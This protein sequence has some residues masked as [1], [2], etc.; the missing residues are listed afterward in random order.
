[1]SSTITYNNITKLNITIILIL[2]Y[3]ILKLKFYIYIPYIV[4]ILL[5]YNSYT[6]IKLNF[7]IN[8]QI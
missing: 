1:M 2:N 4:I 8:Y 3:E 5:K 6:M 7:L